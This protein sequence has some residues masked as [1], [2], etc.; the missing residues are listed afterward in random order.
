EDLKGKVDEKVK[1][2]DITGKEA[3]SLKG[4]LDERIGEI[5]KVLNLKKG[6]F[7]KISRKL[8]YE[9]YNFACGVGAGVIG[10]LKN[11][12]K[13]M[14]IQWFLAALGNSLGETLYLKYP[15]MFEGLREA[16]DSVK[17]A[18]TAIGSLAMLF[19]INAEDQRLNKVFGEG[20]G[21]TIDTVNMVVGGILSGLFGIL[22]G[23]TGIKIYQGEVEDAIGNALIDHGMEWLGKAIKRICGLKIP[24]IGKS[25]S[26][27]IFEVLM[28]GGVT[29]VVQTIVNLI[30]S[31]IMKVIREYIA[32]FFMWLLSKITG[33]S[34]LVTFAVAG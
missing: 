25:I 24:L 15:S 23:L 9:T 28:A 27:A 1:A 6:H 26:Q 18:I 16:G 17:M 30:I 8:K 12:W 31:Y 10:G 20:K 21:E 29:M 3:E 34:I 33:S 4:D 11:A 14:V 22:T 13:Y 5:N 2:G 32:P 19:M 7:H